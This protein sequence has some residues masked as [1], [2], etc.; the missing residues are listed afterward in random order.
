MTYPEANPSRS[1]GSF[2]YFPVY[3]WRFYLL[4]GVLAWNLLT[5]G[6]MGD[7]FTYFS[8]SG[9]P[10]YLLSDLWV[11]I[12]LTFRPL[13]WQSYLLS[14]NDRPFSGTFHLKTLFQDFPAFS[15]SQT[16]KP[17]HPGFPRGPPPWY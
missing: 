16:Q 8:T 1:A 13:G 4:S 7:D 10:S 17:Q 14:R 5:F 2:T 9:C 12:L 15:P 11:P 3:G 6:P